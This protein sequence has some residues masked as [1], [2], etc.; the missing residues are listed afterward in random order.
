VGAESDGVHVTSVFH[1][2][3]VEIDPRYL[4]VW[5]LLSGRPDEELPTWFAIKPGLPD[6]LTPEGLDL[7]WLLGLRDVVVRELS[8]RGWPSTDSA[9]VLIDSAHRVESE[10]GWNYFR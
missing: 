1:Y 8:K 10:G 3:A 6:D 9:S 2:G 7:D 5:I 4:V